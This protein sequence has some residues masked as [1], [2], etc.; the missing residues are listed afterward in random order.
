METVSRWEGVTQMMSPP[1]SGAIGSHAVSYLLKQLKAG[2]TFA[3]FLPSAV[4]LYEGT[5]SSLVPEGYSPAALSEFEAGHVASIAAPKTMTVGSISGTAL[6][7]PTA[8]EELS[9]IIAGS[10]TAPNSYCLLENSIAV[11]GD[12]WL[13]KAKSRIVLHGE[14]VYHLLTSTCESESALVAIREARRSPTLSGAV[15]HMLKRTN[16]VGKESVLATQE[17]QSIAQGVQWIFVSAY[18]GEGY[19]IWHS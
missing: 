9:R 11:S 12:P 17:L 13:L 2:K 14:E 15:G 16:I 8:D 5:I 4:D 18:D 6:P 7:K 3:S 19:L 10:L 1:H